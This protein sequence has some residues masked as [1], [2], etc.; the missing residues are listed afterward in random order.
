METSSTSDSWAT[1][2]T[3]NTVPP[4]IE[5][6]VLLRAAEMYQG[7]AGIKTMK[8]GPLSITYSSEGEDTPEGLLMPF[9]RVAG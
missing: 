1:T 6:A 8:V 3:E 7:T 9:V 2:T 5:R 4:S